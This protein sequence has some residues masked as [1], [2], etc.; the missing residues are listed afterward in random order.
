MFRIGA[1][2]VPVS[3][4]YICLNFKTISELLQH[5]EHCCEAEYI[6][7]TKVERLVVAG[8][9][10]GHLNYCFRQEV[11]WTAGDA[12]QD[13]GGMAHLSREGRD[14]NELGII[15]MGRDSRDPKKLQETIKFGNNLCQ[16]ICRGREL[17][18]MHPLIMRIM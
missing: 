10:I 13:I 4:C 7:I 14:Q 9:I 3:P 1:K 17:T 16:D 15:S 8:G 6:W 12:V 5:L 2:L 18:W 11:N